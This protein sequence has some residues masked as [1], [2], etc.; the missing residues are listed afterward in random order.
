MLDSGCDNVM[1][2]GGWYG[3]ED[4]R[5]VRLG[6]AAG[7]DDLSGGGADQSRH[8][9]AGV[10]DS[11]ARR[12]AFFMNAGSVTVYIRQRLLQ[13]AENCGMQWGGG[14]VIEIDTHQIRSQRSR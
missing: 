2:T 11:A 10:F 1:T 7:K 4:R 8:R 9:L 3:T 5:I 6:A 13:R 12:L 14:V